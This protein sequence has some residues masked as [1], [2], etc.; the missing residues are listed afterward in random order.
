MQRDSGESGYEHDLEGVV[1]F[2]GTLGEFDPVHAGHD[3]IGQQKIET[4][5]PKAFMGIF[6]V[7]EIGD[8]MASLHQSLCQEFP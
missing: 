6:A 3:D 5:T 8:V 1:H 4:A 7:A 2:G